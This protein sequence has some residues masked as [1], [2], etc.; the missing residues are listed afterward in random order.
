MTAARAQRVAQTTGAQR[1]RTEIGQRANARNKREHPPAGTVGEVKFRW[2]GLD[3]YFVQWPEDTTMAPGLWCTA[4]AALEIVK[5]DGQ[6]DEKQ[7][8]GADH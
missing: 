2:A 4:C 7:D 1:G 8:A 5:G 6:D 3:R